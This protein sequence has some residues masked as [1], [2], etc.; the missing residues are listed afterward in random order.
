MLYLSKEDGQGLVE[1]SLILTLV[2]LVVIVSMSFM[3]P[4]VGNVF[5]EIVAAF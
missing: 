4:S 2:A 3:G 1:Y 5:S